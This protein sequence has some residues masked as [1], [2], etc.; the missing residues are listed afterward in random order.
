MR[1]S[2]TDFQHSVATTR[3]YVAQARRSLSC[4]TFRTYGS[5]TTRRTLLTTFFKQIL[6]HLPIERQIGNDLLQSRMPLRE[7]VAVR[8]SRAFRMHKRFFQT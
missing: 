4:Y 1:S 6:K 3:Q 7:P 2:F 5:T 8:E